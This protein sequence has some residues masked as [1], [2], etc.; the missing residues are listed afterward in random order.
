M[1]VK[2]TNNDQR[3]Y[4]GPIPTQEQAVFQLANGLAFIHNNNLAHRDIKPENVL[5]VTSSNGPTL[6][7][8]ADFG[9]CKSVNCNGSYTMS[10]VKGTK[11]WMAPELLKLDDEDS[12]LMMNGH[13]GT[14]QSDVFSAGCLFFYFLTRGVH[15][16][17]SRSS[18]DIVNNIKILNATNIGGISTTLSFILLTFRLC[19]VLS[20]LFLELPVEHFAFAIIFKMI[21]VKTPSERDNWKQ[22]LKD[23]ENQVNNI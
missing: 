5:I 2:H 20:F 12:E 10:G 17:G 11:K 3:K 18:S 19:I 13:R 15:P 8:W 21:L 4:S 16:F 1:F 23:F 22:L 6:L 9:L 7:K 14:I